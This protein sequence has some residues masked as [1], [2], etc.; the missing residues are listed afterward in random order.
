MTYRF[1][2]GSTAKPQGD[3]WGEPQWPPGIASLRD[4]VAEFVR[5]RVSPSNALGPVVHTISVSPTATSS[6]SK[7]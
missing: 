1:A 2:V 6:M 4:R 5:D 7:E 3:L